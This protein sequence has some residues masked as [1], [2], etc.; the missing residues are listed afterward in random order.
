MNRVQLVYKK[1]YMM[2]PSKSVLDA[3]VL[4][5]T[6]VVKVVKVVSRTR[7]VNRE[8]ECHKVSV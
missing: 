1:I 3:V 2:Q 4:I 5:Y 8:H 7:A 6:K